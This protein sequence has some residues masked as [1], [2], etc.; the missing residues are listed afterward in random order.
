MY[1]KYIHVVLIKVVTLLIVIKINAE[2]H[3]LTKHL[4][5]TGNKTHKH[6]NLYLAIC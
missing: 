6:C 5:V 1:T 4:I 2:K 3:F